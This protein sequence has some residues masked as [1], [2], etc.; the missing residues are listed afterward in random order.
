[1]YCTSLD[2]EW[3]NWISSEREWQAANLAQIRRYPVTPLKRLTH[4]TLGSISR[5]YWDDRK[6]VLY[7]AVQYRGQVAH[8]AAI[9]PATGAI[10]KIVDIKGAALYY[11]CSL[12]WDPES[13]TL[14]YTTD[15]KQ[16]RDLN[17]VQ[18]D[19]GRH[20]ML[21][22]DM[23]VGDLVFDRTAHVLWAIRRTDG[24]S[25]VVRIAPPY[26]EWTEVR[27]CEYGYDLF[28]L[29]ISPDGKY[30]TAGETD[31]SGRQ[32][33]VRIS[34]AD[35]AAPVQ[36]LHDFEFN[37]P[38]N[39]VHSADGRYL[40]GTSYYTG[41]SNVFRYEFATQ[42][43][44]VL[45]N[46]ETGLFRPLPLED[47]RLLALEYTASGFV[48]V[49]MPAA[50]VEDVSA[51]AYLGQQVAERWPVVKTWKLGSPQE[52]DLERLGV[53]SG[54]YNPRVLSLLSAYPVVEGYKNYAAAGW[55]VD[56]G[57]KVMLSSLTATLSFSPGPERTHAGFQYR[58]WN[59]KV[60]GAYNN[61][62]FYD[63][64]GPTKSSYK[65]YFLKVENRH[66]LLYD[67]PRTVDLEWSVAGYGGL[68]RLPDYQ[69]V[70][71]PYRN[72]LTGKLALNYSFVDRS[73][74]AVDDEKGVRWQLA[75][76]DNYAHGTML[77]RVYGTYDYGFLLPMKNSPIWLRTAAGY[78]FGNRN[79]A[80][81]NFYFGAFGNNWVDRLE[82][83]RYREY[84]SFPGVELDQIGAKSF[85]RALAEWNL[86]PVRFRHLG[87]PYLY[88]NWMRLS[89]FGGGLATDGG[90]RYRD[91][92]AQLDFR[93]VP[94]SYLNSTFS[95][96]YAVAKGNRTPRSG[97]FMI[98]LKLL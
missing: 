23:R 42:K 2:R 68:E 53:R 80:L 36:V 1:V 43:M 35:P 21:V 8:L 18:P 57:D 97:E 92:G 32:K 50:P 72:Y 54:T 88:C 67:M 60:T 70:A 11:V 83:S 6:H 3:R 64:F 5:M 55:R 22:R 48:P 91:A 63:L 71:A 62:D 74:G 90:R 19:T 86:P 10:R 25:S 82:T 41:A 49:E 7:A 95:L 47:G 79:E 59:W 98:S 31:L 73:P 9:D 96:G 78:G 89:L 66:F 52:I 44:D 29:D 24:L 38:E 28:D 94:F 46:A 13:R 84:A 33:L 85:G 15:N 45:S 93:I 14:F 51:V 81:A 27:R 58:Y 77:P 30:L 65:G 75:L 34:T 26:R 12:A 87:V 61:A 76:R 39:F 4:T 37:S 16:W 40:Y 69:N 17:I 20:Q 56:M